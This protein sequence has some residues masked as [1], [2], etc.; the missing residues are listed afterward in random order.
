MSLCSDKGEPQMAAAQIWKGSTPATR[1]H[2][3]NLIQIWTTHL[4]YRPL[5][6]NVALKSN[7]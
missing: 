2:V 3:N 1:K 5:T 4:R 7:T 6:L